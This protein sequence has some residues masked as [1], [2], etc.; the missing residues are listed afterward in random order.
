ML[1]FGVIGAGRI[2]KDFCDAAVRAD[3][4]EVVAVFY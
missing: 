4:T 2:A 3:G 1:R